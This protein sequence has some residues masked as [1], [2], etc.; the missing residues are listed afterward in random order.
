MVLNL[1]RLIGHTSIHSK[2]VVLSF[3]V[4]KTRFPYRNTLN[5]H[6]H[7]IP[8][9]SIQYGR[10]Y[11]MFVTTWAHLFLMDRYALSSFPASTSLPLKQ[12]RTGYEEEQH[13]QQS[14][15]AAGVD[16]LLA[17]RIAGREDIG[18]YRDGRE[19]NRDGNV[20]DGEVEGQED[21]A[22]NNEDREAEYEAGEDEVEESG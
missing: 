7:S 22:V 11:E 3:F 14:S 17:D 5:P 16:P 20:V 13:L 19:E 8:L 21:S 12:T 1:F 15:V 4:Y 10:R 2:L 9:I 6:L 18:S